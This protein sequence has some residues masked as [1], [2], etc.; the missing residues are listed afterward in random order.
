[1]PSRVK[2]T[3]PRSKKENKEPKEITT[4]QVEH[5]AST[6]ITT[7]TQAINTKPK[8]TSKQIRS[9]KMLSSV[10]NTSVSNRSCLNT[11]S[12][13]KITDYFQIRKSSR[14]T[15]SDLEKEKRCL[16]EEMIKNCVEDGLEV[17]N[18]ADKGRG[19]FANKYFNKGDF[20]CEYAGEMISY[21]SAK[22]REEMYAQDTTIGCYMYFFEYKTK[23]FCI[24]ATAETSRLGR[25]LNHSKTEGNC[26]TQLFEINSKPHLILI[27]ARDI[28]PGEE[29][30]YDYGDRNKNSIESHPW[31]AK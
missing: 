2:K 6:E 29:M 27:A 10:L 26:R 9:V 23:I 31:L 4:D 21:Q 14:K 8:K 19:V 12:N 22:K 25:L 16:F 28:K 20:V 15:K 30:L 1:M 17:R 7:Q 18:M 13:R 11:S 5:A 24:D 3:K